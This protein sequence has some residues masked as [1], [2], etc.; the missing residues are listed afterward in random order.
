MKEG[1]LTLD[2]YRQIAEHEPFDLPHTRALYIAMGK[3]PIPTRPEDAAALGL[4]SPGQA[5]PPGEGRASLRPA[6]SRCPAKASRRRSPR[7][8]R[9]GTRP[10]AKRSP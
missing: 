3:T 6:P 10:P 1:L 2:E 9:A 4:A 5:P 7:A 8:R